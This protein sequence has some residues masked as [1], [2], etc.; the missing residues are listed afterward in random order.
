[1]ACPVLLAV[2]TKKVDLSSE[3]NTGD[4][5]SIVPLAA[6]SLLLCP[7]AFFPLGFAILRRSIAQGQAPAAPAPGQQLTLSL[8]ILLGWT[9]SLVHVSAILQMV[10]A[11]KIF[12]L[13]TMRLGVVLWTSLIAACVIVGVLW[14]W[15]VIIRIAYYRRGEAWEAAD[16][17]WWHKKLELLLDLSAA[18]TSLLFLGLEGL[19]LE[20]Q[21]SGLGKDLIPSLRTPVGITFG[22]CV[23]ASTVMAVATVPPMDRSGDAANDNRSRLLRTVIDFFCALLAMGLTLVVTMIL[24]HLVLKNKRAAAVIEGTVAAAFPWFILF[25][26]YVYCVLFLP[27]AT[28]NLNNGQLKPASLEMTKVTFTA[29]LAISLPSFRGYHLSDSTG[30]FIVIAAMSVIFGIGWRLFSHFEQKAAL[31]TSKAAFLCTN[32]WLAA[33]AIALLVMAKQ[34]LPV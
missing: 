6:V 30:A 15:S 9:K 34:A 32:T 28:G 17:C 29:F 24:V 18:V 8:C 27:G 26:I 14:I 19:A 25:L 11:C 33:A 20:G 12:L 2:A 10:L 31:W 4:Q 3:G 1:M 7:F 22:C 5:K 16:G 13:I 21:T 23:G